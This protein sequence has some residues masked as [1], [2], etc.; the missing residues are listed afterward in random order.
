MRKFSFR[1]LI[2]L[3][4]LTIIGCSRGPSAEEEVYAQLEKVV[5]LEEVFEQQQEPLVA[6][7]QQEKEI[8]NEIIALSMKEFDKIVSLSKEAIAITNKRQEHLNKEKESI[9]AAKV[10][11]EK[12]KASIDTI[13]EEALKK[14]ALELYELMKGRYEAY[15]EL[16]THYQEALS[17]DKKLYEMFQNEDLTLD[18]LETQINKINEMYDKVIAANERFNDFTNKYNN[19]KLDFYKAAGLDV[20]YSQET[21]D[22]KSN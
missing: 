20:T 6:L 5:T 21:E 9:E 11:F 1:L 2:F 4:V 10:A 16:Y 8:Y 19:S 17:E 22:T 14:Q 18:V 12:T 13:K 15:D 7:E 3:S